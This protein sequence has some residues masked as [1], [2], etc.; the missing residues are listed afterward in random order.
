MASLLDLRAGEVVEDEAEPAASDRPGFFHTL[1]GMIFHP[2]RTLDAGIA[3]PV[4][5]YAWALAAL[6]GLYLGHVVTISE[7]TGRAWPFAATLAWIAIAGPVC[8]IAFLYVGGLMLN[9]A[10]DVLD[11]HAPRKKIRSL[12]GHA[13][14][15]GLVAFLCFGI[16][17]ILLF[18]ERLF[19]EGFVPEGEEVLG[20]GLL[21]GDALCFAWSAGLLIH[22]LRMLTGFS[23]RRAMG[24]VA[25]AA[26]PV[27]LVAGLMAFIILGPSLGGS[28]EFQPVQPKAPASAAR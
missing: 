9:W 22:G 12:L 3:H 20:W 2:V 17:R 24:V 8:G 21:L 28:D 23:P 25:L 26:A 15:P 18:E 7:R 1:F 13:G 16:P 4:Q 10:S 19:R 6:G 27:I 5:I 14:V 11:G